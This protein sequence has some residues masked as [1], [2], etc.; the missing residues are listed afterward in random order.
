MVILVLYSKFT[1]IDTERSCDI[2][3]FILYI[4]WPYNRIDAWM[5]LSLKAY[6]TT[7]DNL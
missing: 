7:F 6:T 3:K 4:Q 1:A 2:N 5:V